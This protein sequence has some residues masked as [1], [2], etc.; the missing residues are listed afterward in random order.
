MT[1][2]PVV[3]P[4]FGE[5]ACE[6]FKS[7]KHGV[8]EQK[9]HPKRYRPHDQKDPVVYE[10]IP[11]PAAIHKINQNGALKPYQMDERPFDFNYDGLAHYGMVPDMLQDLTNVD[12]PKHDRQA[13][14]ESAEGYLKMW[15]KAERAK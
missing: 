7:Y 10:G 13:L 14:F 8:A 9:A 2:I 1:F 12:M 15:E 11:V 4:R 5:H 3:S 6:G